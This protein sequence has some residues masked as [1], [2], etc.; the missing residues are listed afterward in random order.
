MVCSRLEKGKQRSCAAEQGHPPPPAP[1]APFRGATCCTRTRTSSVGKREG[2]FTGS[3]TGFAL[4][5]LRTQL[6]SRELDP[7][8][9]DGE[10]SSRFLGRRSRRPQQCC[11]REGR[12]SHRNVSGFSGGSLKLSRVVSFASG[13]LSLSWV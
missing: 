11:G 10:S 13:L 6:P 12:Y 7:D 3:R 1:S 2:V 5:S 4:R 8:N 9:V